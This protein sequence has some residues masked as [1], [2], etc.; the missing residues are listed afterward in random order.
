MIEKIRKT[1]NL[2]IVFWLIKDCCWVSDFKLLGVLMIFPTLIISIFIAWK[3]RHSFSELVH[4]IAVTSWICANSIWMFGE[5]FY[6][7]ST[8]PIAQ[9]F[10]SIGIIVLVAFYTWKIFQSQE[11]KGVVQ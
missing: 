7:D 2:H 8:R 3:M 9:V 5:F 10:F 11:S 1:E 6:N 4:N